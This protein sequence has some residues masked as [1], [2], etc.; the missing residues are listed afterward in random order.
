MGRVD[1]VGAAHLGAGLRGGSAP[2]PEDAMVE[3]MCGKHLRTMQRRGQ[4]WY[5]PSPI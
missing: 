4:D 1:L 2:P 3:A 5:G